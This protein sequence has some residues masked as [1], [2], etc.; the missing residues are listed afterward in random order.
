MK[1]PKNSLPQGLFY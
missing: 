1:D